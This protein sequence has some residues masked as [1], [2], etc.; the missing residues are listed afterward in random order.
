MN[1]I[2]SRISLFI[3]VAVAATLFSCRR[4]APRATLMPWDS[5]NEQIDSLLDLAD[6]HEFAAGADA[7]PTLQVLTQ[8]DSIANRDL[9][10]GARLAGAYAKMKLDD[11]GLPREDLLF[12]FPDLLRNPAKEESDIDH[13]YLRARIKLAVA[14]LDDDL[15]R[16]TD[17]LFGILP[18]FL[19]AA[20]SMRVVETLYELNLS[21][22]KVWDEPTQIEYMHEILRYVP[23]SIPELK[24][25]IRSNIV[26]L[27]RNHKEDGKYLASLD[28][29][30]REKDLLNL[31]PALGVIVYSDLYR[32]Q[33]NE[34]F[35]DSAALF[36]KTVEVEHDAE[37]VYCI[38]RL[39]QAVDKNQPDSAGNFAALLREKL[40]EDYT[41]LDIESM[42]ALV[43]YYESVGNSEEADSMRQ[44]LSTAR[45]SAEAYEKAL[46]MARMN[47]DRRIGDFRE[48][49]VRR[50]S[51]IKTQTV[52]W[53]CVI[54]ALFIL[55]AVYIVLRLRK[56]HQLKN[57]ALQDDLQN[58]KRR[59]TVETMRRAEKEMAINSVLKDLDSMESKERPTRRRCARSCVCSSPAMTTG[60]G[61]PR[62]SP[63]CGPVL[64][65][66]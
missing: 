55:I 14:L 25:V 13:P 11:S 60:N 47:A 33:G 19:D 45:K 31:A 64:W 22:G 49:S 59:L 29:L 66:I 3:L 8:I 17:I 20:D 30:R 37:R 21:Y 35:L 53:I 7:T 63:K 2:S 58:A 52:V 50:E 38:Q 41:P 62:C 16:K 10:V 65:R 46:K 18:A 51:H 56:K 57:I 6:R 44:K 23:D 54:S 27:E 43:A 48:Y 39:S 1:R 61:L 36:M 9:S 34:A 15:E 5:G 40:S 4:S 32:L 26:R 24:G 28:S 42:K 12:E